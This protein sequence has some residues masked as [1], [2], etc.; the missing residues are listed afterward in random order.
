MCVL[1]NGRQIII[2]LKETLKGNGD[3]KL[4]LLCLEDVLVQGLWNCI[5]SKMDLIDSFIVPIY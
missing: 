1:E 3:C 4:V 2:L 5:L